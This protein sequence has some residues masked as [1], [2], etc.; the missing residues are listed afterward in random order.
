MVATTLRQEVIDYVDMLDEEQ[1]Q[2]ALVYVRNLVSPK[3]THSNSKNPQERIEAR[4]ALDEL[5]ALIRPAK[6]EISM[7][8][9]KEAAIAMRRKYESI[10]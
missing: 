1:T 9:E 3:H 7:N 2:L 10:D 8:G 6:H 5:F 4:K